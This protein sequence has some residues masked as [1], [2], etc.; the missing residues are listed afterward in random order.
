MWFWLRRPR[1]TLDE[2]TALIVVAL[3]SLLSL[4]IAFVD[5]PL[6]SMMKRDA[7]LMILLGG[8]A[9]QIVQSCTGSGFSVGDGSMS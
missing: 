2:S 1:L 9:V 7:E 3:C 5:W 4:S 8:V 6:T